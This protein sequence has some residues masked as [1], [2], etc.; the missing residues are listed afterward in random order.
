[1]SEMLASR[2]TKR[3]VTVFLIKTS[4]IYVIKCNVGFLIAGKNHETYEQLQGCRYTPNYLKGRNFVGKKIWWIWW[5]C[6][7]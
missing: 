2:E 6:K 4:R 1:M 7:N 5:I 3:S